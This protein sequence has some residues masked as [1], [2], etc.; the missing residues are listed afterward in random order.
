MSP[1][2]YLAVM[3]TACIGA[4]I[5][6]ILLNRETAGDRFGWIA[7][8]GRIFEC[9]ANGHSALSKQLVGE[10][11]SCPNPEKHLINRGW[12]KY[13]KVYSRQ[14][15]NYCFTLGVGDNKEPT[16][17]QIEILEQMGFDRLLEFSSCEFEQQLIQECREMGMSDEEI[18]SWMK[19]I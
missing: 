5:A 14:T 8:D 4:F 13:S 2:T 3:C 7:P 11:H 10:I 12:V 18:E 1:W 16:D 17:A 9:R 15:K 19:E 6:S